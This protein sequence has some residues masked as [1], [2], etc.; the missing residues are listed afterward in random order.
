MLKEWGARSFSKMFGEQ[1]VSELS[2]F[3]Q[4][5]MCKARSSS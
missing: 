1:V 3:F 5:E 4:V 2:E